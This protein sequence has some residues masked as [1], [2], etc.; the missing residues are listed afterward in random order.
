MLGRGT[1]CNDQ[2]SALGFPIL[3]IEKESQLGYLQKSIERC[4]QKTFFG[5]I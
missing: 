4:Q 1:D 2:I 3:N 5:F